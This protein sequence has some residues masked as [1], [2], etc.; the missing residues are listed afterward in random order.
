MFPMYK[1]LN[2]HNHLISCISQYFRLKRLLMK[3]IGNT[4]LTVCLKH[5]KLTLLK[6]KTKSMP[7]PSDYSWFCCG[8]L[9]LPEWIIMI[10]FSSIHF[11]YLSSRSFTKNLQA[12]RYMY[13]PSNLCKIE[14]ENEICRLISIHTIFWNDTFADYCGIFQ[15]VWYW[16]IKLFLE[17][18]VLFP[19]IISN[20]S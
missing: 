5:W 8:K 3:T 16:R 19:E 2:K 18:S 12:K 10:P 20:F 15:N 13:V 17:Y 9:Q 7:K 6:R 1:G 11:H 4:F 14:L